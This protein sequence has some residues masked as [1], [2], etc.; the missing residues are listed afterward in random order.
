[1]MSH[2]LRCGLLLSLAVVLMLP[3]LQPSAAR[4]EVTRE[5]VEQAIKDAVRYLKG[6]QNADG[7]WDDADNRAPNGTTA[8][9]TLALLTA[10]EPI[11]DKNMAMALSN[12]EKYDANRLGKTYS[13]ALQTMVFAQA[14]PSRYKVQL[15]DNV[16]WLERA[17]IQPNDRVQWP[18]S[19][20]YDEIKSSQGDNSNTQ[21]ALLGLHAASEAGIPVRPQVWALSR[22][23]WEVAQRQNGFDRGGWGYYPGDRQSATASMTCAGVASLLICG[24]KRFEGRETLVGDQ[25]RNCG[26][27]GFNPALQAG[28]DWLSAHFRISE[29]FGARGGQLWKYYFLY[30]LERTGRLSGLRYFGN[31]DWYFEGAEHLVHDPNRDPLQGKWTGTGSAETNPL[32]T[33][34][35]VLLFLAKGRSPVLINK[36]RHGPGSDWN[37]DR[38]DVRN[39]TNLVSREWKHLVTFQVVD[40]ET[41]SIEEL[42]QAPI[43]FFNGH[44]PP[45]FGP[46]AKKRLRQYVEQG[47]LIFAEACCSRP[48]FDQGLRSLV[49]ELFPEP[50]YNLQPLSPSHAVWRAKYLL[51]PDVHP[52]WGVEFG[53]RTA[54]IYSP[55]DLSCFWNQMEQQP[56]NPAVIKATRVAQNIIDYAT[57][58]ELPADKLAPRDVTEIPRETPKR[59]ALHIAKLR[60]SG[61]WNVAPLAIPN[62]TTFLRQSDLR[63]DVVITHREITS[64]RDPNLVYYPLVYLHGRAGFNFPEADMEAIRKHLDPGAGLLFADAACGSEAFDTSFRKFC[65]ELYPDHP[66]EPIPP[67]DE[68][69]TEQ[70]GFDLS[71]VHFSTAAGGAVGKPQLEGVKLNNRWAVI[72]SKYDLGCSLERQQGLDCKGYVHESALRIASNIVIYSTLP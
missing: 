59:G 29:N 17:Q 13:V 25:I 60:H 6:R 71:D 19:W 50:E 5:E 40:P 47:G 43:L 61:E 2:C 56:D 68:L 51:T 69:Y 27:G 26:S 33:T 67:D 12:L 20:T 36:L 10:G 24:S 22:Q 49:E 7:S 65:A 1:M 48:E 41:S 66:L 64:P 44:Q 70:C 14:D 21:Y 42:L 23:Y 3:S 46:E 54:L 15:L 28:V 4:A 38:D 37:N 45:E 31:H 58:R 63:F 55:G 30:G 11:T 62:L 16:Q 35:F 8:L 32:V 18:G 34:S 9:V 72:Y 39:L 52:L 53:C 57:G